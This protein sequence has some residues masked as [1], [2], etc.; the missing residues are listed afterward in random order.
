MNKKTI[1]KIFILIYG[2]SLTANACNIDHAMLLFRFLLYKSHEELSVT[3][4]SMV[5]IQQPTPNGFILYRDPSMTKRKAN[6]LTNLDLSYLQM[7]KN[8][9]TNYRT[10][11][12]ADF[13]GTNL[14]GT[15]K[16]I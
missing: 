10:Q 11:E 15:V 9:F 12:Q 2:L 6:D 7:K 4:P 8:D 14:T 3:F 1:A 16:P 13:T 5:G